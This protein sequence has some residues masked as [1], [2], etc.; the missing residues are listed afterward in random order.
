MYIFVKGDYFLFGLVFIKKKQLNRIFFKKETKPVQTD[1]FRFGLVFL[2]K[3]RFGL[4][5]FPVWLGFFLVWLSFFLVF[6]YLGSVQ[7][8]SVFFISGL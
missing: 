2:D 1:R 7:F 3:N 4:G 8:D 5:F 6:F